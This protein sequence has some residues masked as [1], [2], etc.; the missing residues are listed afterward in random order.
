MKRNVLA[1][2]VLSAVLVL[3]ACAGPRPSSPLATAGP[4]ARPA[5]FSAGGEDLPPEAVPPPE[6]V[7]AASTNSRSVP[8]PAAAPPGANIRVN[9]PAFAQGGRLSSETHVAVSGPNVVVGFNDFSLDPD[10]LISG[11]SFSTD[12]G[13]SFVQRKV[14]PVPG[15]TNG[16]DPVLAIGPSG[17]VYYAQLARLPSPTGLRSIIGVSKSTDRGATFT[18]PVDASTS[19]R[20][21]FPDKPW[22]EVDRG[23]ASPHRGNVYV[24]WT[25]IVN[26][27]SVSGPMI[28]FSRSTDG[29][30]SFQPAL[31]LTEVGPAP[32]PNLF[33][34]GS[35]IAVA[36]SGDVYLG[37]AD[38][39]GGTAKLSV[40]RSTDG[41]ASFGA[42]V[43]AAD[44]RGVFDVT[45]GGLVRMHSWPFLAVSP[46]GTVHA[47]YCGRREAPGSDAADV[48]HVRSTDR[49]ATWSAP[50]RVNDDETDAA[51]FHPSVAVLPDGTLG[52]KWFDRR[53]DAANDALT[54]V[55]MAFSADDG[56]TFSAN[57]R[58]SDQAWPFFSTYGSSYHG[59]YDGLAAGDDSFWLSWSDERGE[60]ADAYAALVPRTRNPAAPDFGI[61]AASVWAS[62]RAGGSVEIPIRTVAEHGFAGDVVLS[63]AAETPEP[64][65][66]SFSFDRPQVAAGETAHLSVTAAP[67]ATPGTR[68]VVAAATASGVT[69]KAT[70]RVTMQEAGRRFSLPVNVS[71]SKGNSSGRRVVRVDASGRW[72]AAFLDESDDPD[73]PTVRYTSSPDGR[74]FRPAVTLSAPGVPVSDSSL[75]LDGLG[76]PCVLYTARPAGERPRIYLRRSRDGGASFEPARPLSPEGESH[77]DGLLV[78][79]PAG[80]ALLATRRTDPPAGASQGS[81]YFLKLQA[82]FDDAATFAPLPDLETVST[83]PS[84]P[85]RAAFGPNGE[86]YVLYTVPTGNDSARVV[87]AWSENLRDFRP[88]ELDASRSRI[89]S[90]L[91]VL[92][93]GR[94]LVASARRFANPAAGAI[95]RRSRLLSEGSGSR[96]GLQ[97]EDPNFVAR[98]LFQAE[99]FR[100]DDRGETFSDALALGGASLTAPPLGL[101]PGDGIVTATWRESEIDEAGYRMRILAAVSRS[102]G[103]SF[104]SPILVSAS[105]GVVLTVVPVTSSDATPR[106]AWVEDGPAN[107]D[108][109]VSAYEAPAGPNGAPAASI[110][111]PSGAA[112]F[113]AG[114]EVR[115]VGS[116]TDPEGD[117][118]ELLWEMGDGSPRFGRELGYSFARPGTYAVTLRARDVRGAVSAPTTRS[119]VV[120]ASTL[121]GASLLLPVVVEA[122]GLAGSSYRSELVLVSRS[123]APAEVELEFFPEGRGSAGV[124]R[125]T[126]APFEQRFLPGVVSFLRQRGL[127][128]AASGPGRVGALKATFR[129]EADASRVYAGVRTFTRDPAGGAG[130]FGLF[131]SAVEPTD[132]PWTLP[133]LRQDE[134]QRSNVA[135]VNG[136]AEPITLRVSLFGPNGEPLGDLP[137][138][139]LGP[140]DWAQFVTPLFGKA[141][142]GRAVVS[143]VAGSSKFAAYATSL[144]A[145]TSDGSYIP[146][147]S[148]RREGPLF[149]PVV[150][151]QPGLF[152][153][154]F[155]TDV[156][157][158]NFTEAPLELTLRYRDQV[159]TARD[160]EARVTLAPGELRTLEDVFSF[161]ESAIPI[162]PT[163]TPFAIGTLLVLP[164][165]GT[166]PGAF[167]VGAR[168]YTGAPGGSS[169]GTFGLFYPAISGAEAASD[170][171]YVYGLRGGASERS[172]LAVAS[173]GDG[174]DDL[175]LRVTLFASD[176]KV[177]TGPF[178]VGPFRRGGWIQYDDLQNLPI[179]G[180]A[181]VERASGSSRF[182]AYGTRLDNVTSDGSYLAMT[183]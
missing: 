25:H 178:S 70:L 142:A 157:L 141:T 140:Y 144:D 182:V 95:R 14:P 114:E 105:H 3:S 37:F 17:E 39:R 38:P 24:A 55:L 54:E 92:P 164:P 104:S 113:E 181:K 109:F 43:K 98:F 87:V 74:T 11:Y 99:L 160:G 72:H 42:P 81:H 126:L 63:A 77:E 41:G 35:N 146:A 9:D 127:A 27:S 128:V 110:V 168:T 172:N 66:L 68:R 134:R 179:G 152:G 112:A 6:R 23:A 15:G 149:V 34:Q 31:E 150:V 16:G 8:G 47:V 143:R 148:R 123:P 116:A 125:L 180:Y 90:D 52:T 119:V 12:G 33:L 46:G 121:A 171:A 136:G 176:G 96:R 32:A 59:D 58:V 106:V 40:V 135:I 61:G 45:G 132:G 129:G 60:D 100:S 169:G 21:A 153:S 20:D 13:S 177:V 65:D 88:R 80:R 94:L 111:E 163:N 158:T 145:A 2:T 175:V 84:A 101:A 50:R 124:T 56:V 22:I 117:A 154:F 93:S 75:A 49:G 107:L 83:D 19:P 97:D 28:A 138:R 167:A 48:F 102:E 159:R 78:F 51:Q 10:G 67:G 57:F 29:G 79:G 64:S 120:K 166:P 151:R 103:E 44:V 108:L 122:D 53:I 162:P 137:D 36:P 115:F 82:S 131:Y 156:S 165:A 155:R 139:T 7:Q 30:G 174:A 130:T 85:V 1:G 76:N 147:D 62:L 161:L 71:R 69:R 133:G 118:V 73:K 18:P 91:A 89:G 86:A 26:G 170:V 5:P 173:F 183:K 4:A